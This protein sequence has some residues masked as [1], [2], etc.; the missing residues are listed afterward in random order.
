MYVSEG[1][2]R[3]N[4]AA[5]EEKGLDTPNERAKESQGMYLPG[6]TDVGIIDR[7]EIGIIILKVLIFPFLSVVTSCKGVVEGENRRMVN[8][9]RRWA[10]LNMRA[11]RVGEDETTG[12]AHYFTNM[13][14]PPP[15]YLFVV[16]QGRRG[17]TTL[18]LLETAPITVDGSALL[19]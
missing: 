12:E 9:G 18:N 7:H 8:E 4:V 2:T 17:E 15:V 3:G 16:S 13:S 6:Y 11:R 14:Y 19:Y 1:K 5:N 10:I